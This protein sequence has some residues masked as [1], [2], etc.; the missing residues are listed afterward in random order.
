MVFVVAFLMESFAAEFT[1][2]WP[3]SLMDPHV[4]VQGG[5]PVE[6]LA[7]G[8]AF[9]RFFGRVNDLVAAQG[10]SLPEAFAADL[11]DERSSTCIHQDQ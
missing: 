10:R 4:G 2:V 7:T 11:A 3:I 9:V 5:A 6:G 1:D 8:L